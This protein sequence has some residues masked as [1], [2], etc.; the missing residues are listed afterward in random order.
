MAV[1]A[2][3]GI[4][5]G[6]ACRTGCEKAGERARASAGA[7]RTAAQSGLSLRTY[8]RRQAVVCSA[9]VE[10]VT[11]DS[12]QFI[13]EEAMLASHTFP[14]PADEL[15]A[16]AKVW[17]AKISVDPLSLAAD[18][19]DDFSFVA[20]VVG[21]LTGPQLL[22][23]FTSFDL[24]TGIPNLAANYHHFRVDPFEPGRVWFTT[25][26]TGTHTGTIAGSIKP[27]GI[28]FECPPQSNSVVFNEEGKV[29]KY[30]IG[31][32]MDRQ[33]GNSGGLGGVYGILYAIGAGL[34]FPEGQPWK[35]SKRYRLFQWMGSLR[36]GN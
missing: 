8:G 27:T 23:A 25:R 22:K 26:P 28:D 35:A 19:A 29:V 11:K 7:L 15:I 16:K 32:V 6:A 33:V 9:S 10:T 30:T 13:D 21:P 12:V 36:S 14:I 34:P 5:H 4:G 24:K 1:V 18:M 20:P 2:I 31:Y 17:A 3:R